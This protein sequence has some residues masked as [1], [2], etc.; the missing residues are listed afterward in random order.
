MERRCDI[1]ATAI[2]EAELQRAVCVTPNDRQCGNAN[3]VE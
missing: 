3:E 2:A 1:G